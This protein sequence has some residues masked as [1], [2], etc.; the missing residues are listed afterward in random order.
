MPERGGG[1]AETT[2]DAV[3]PRFESGACDTHIHFYDR[4]HRAA[5][6]ALLH[7]ADAGLDDYRE[8]QA[9]LGLARVV[10]VQPTT[11]GLDNQCQLE[12]VSDM[13]ADARA[14]VVVDDTVSNARLTEL[15]ALGARGARFHMLPG[16]AVPWSIM[17]EVARRIE[18]FGWH[19]QLQ[20]DGREL[21]GRVR[22]LEA[23]PTPLVVDHMGLFTPPVEPDH[24]SFRALSMLLAGGGCWVKLSAP[25]LSSVDGPPTYA[26]AGRVARALVAAAP[27]RMVWASNWPHPGW[28][29]PPSPRRLGALFANWVPDAGTRRMI[30]TSN[31]AEL[32]GFGPP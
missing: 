31:P 22:Q 7:P 27:E 23:L 3:A 32:Y 6:T 1:G 9:E 21:A 16:G 25:Y 18:P 15:T 17:D 28:D 2:A 20:L 10:V 4:H 30:L 24:E 8:F 11:Y 13:G 19:I 14:V 29:D 5:S 26:D 12:R